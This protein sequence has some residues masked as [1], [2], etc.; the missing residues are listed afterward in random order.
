[1]QKHVAW[2]SMQRH[3]QESITTKEIK[4]SFATGTAVT[5]VDV[6]EPDEFKDWHIPGALNVPV[7]RILAGETPP[8]SRGPIA[9]ICA[10]GPR[11]KQAAEALR[12]RG[13]PA[14][15]V[16][17]GMVAWNS[18]YRAIDVDASTA[19]ILQVQRLGKSCLSY[20]VISKGEALVI[21]PSVDIDE[22]VRAT[23]D[24]GARITLVVDTHAHADHVSGARAL[25]DA[26][27]ATYWAPA[28]LGERVKHETLREGS[29]LRV[30]AASLRVIE[31]PGHT[32]GSLTLVM[33]DV[34]FTGDTLFAE[35][36]GRPDLGQD[37]RPNAA[38]L[39]ASLHD[40]LLTLPSGT[41][42]LPA[43]AGHLLD[44]KDGSPVLATLGDLVKHQ[45]ALRIGKK[46][47][48]EW[49][50]RNT[51]PKPGNFET[52]KHINRGQEAMPPIDDVH[53][54]EAGP[55]RCAVAG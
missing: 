49:V 50:A 15:H 34:A 42:V 8:N 5:L 29:T 14:R 37:P 25:A 30:G 3:A 31:T 32:P 16:E 44:P 47:F 10:H 11:S 22:Y 52:I 1:M 4:D 18:T 24:A 23:S 13:V 20:L 45:E 7:G 38:V 27:G 17:G 2:A 21:D 39:Y 9:T 41:R 43:H 48:V 28:E 19:R 53:E 33:D 35:S 40:R 26:T 54:L 12:A 6:R 36:V 51:T 55:N 46:D